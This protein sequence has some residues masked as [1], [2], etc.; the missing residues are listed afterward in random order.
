MKTNI[1]DTQLKFQ[2]EK[3]Q[4]RVKKA[5]MYTSTYITSKVLLS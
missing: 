5:K 3:P 4:S 2:L 1:T